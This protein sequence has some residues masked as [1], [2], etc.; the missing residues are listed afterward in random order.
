M[1]RVLLVIIIIFFI[2]GTSAAQTGPWEHR[3]T[4]SK[5]QTQ[6]PFTAF[7]PALEPGVYDLTAT[8]Y[9]AAGNESDYAIPVMNFTFPTTGATGLAWNPNTQEDL[10]GYKIY[11]RSSDITPPSPPAGC[12]IY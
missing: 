10:A 4:V 7:D 12:R 3:A 5:D 8:T 1:K 11:I 9:D 6:C 2:L